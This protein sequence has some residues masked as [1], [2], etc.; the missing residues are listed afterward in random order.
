MAAPP[1]QRRVLQ[2][3]LQILGQRTRRFGD[4]EPV[5]ETHHH[6]AQRIDEVD[7]PRQAA[8]RRW[9]QR[10]QPAGIGTGDVQRIG[11]RSTGQLPLGRLAAVGQQPYAGDAIHLAGLRQACLA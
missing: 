8:G 2:Q 5:V 10:S 3:A 9:R 1:A 11:Q 6:V 4:V 7:R